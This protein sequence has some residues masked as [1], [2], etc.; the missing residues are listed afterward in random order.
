MRLEMYDALV[1]HLRERVAESA[2][3][4]LVYLCM[5]P[6]DVWRR[7]F[8]EPGPTSRELDLRFEDTYRRRF[9]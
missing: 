8:G 7:V 4:P 5:E 2:S 9:R 1:R 3:Q 6:P